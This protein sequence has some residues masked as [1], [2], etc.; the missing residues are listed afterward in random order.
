[1]H[2]TRTRHCL[3][4]LLSIS[5]V[6]Q[7]KGA[8]SRPRTMRAWV[9]NTSSNDTGAPPIEAYKC[10]RSCLRVYY[11]AYILTFPLFLFVFSYFPLSPL[12]SSRF[13]LER[14]QWFTEGITEFA[15][16]RKHRIKAFAM[17]SVFPLSVETGWNFR[18]DEARLLFKH[19]V[20]SSH[21][22]IAASR[23][24]DK[25]YWKKCW[26][27]IVRTKLVSYF[28]YYYNGRFSSN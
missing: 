1:M 21:R 9:S 18:I 12:L 23:N 20:V 8:R 5:G 25:L 4:K 10:E 2:D 27:N 11:H 7:G 14:I 13:L 19:F 16:Q 17:Q 6:N 15:S 28:H 3:G 24:A 22:F 26:S